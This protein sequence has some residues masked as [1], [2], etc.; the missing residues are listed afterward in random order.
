MEVRDI[1]NILLHILFLF[2]ILSVLFWKII[3]TEM[4]DHTEDAL[5]GPINTQL[6]NLT[7]KLQYNDSA[8]YK[9]PCNIIKNHKESV[10]K[11][12]NGRLSQLINEEPVKKSH[13]NHLKKV[14]LG[15]GLGL[16]VATILCGIWLSYSN[17]K[18][19]KKAHASGVQVDPE[20]EFHT[21]WRI[22]LINVG[23]FIGVGICEVIFFLFIAS[24][25]VP[26]GSSDASDSVIEQLIESFNNQ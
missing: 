26:I 22:I 24:K 13:N 17:H 23:L 10:A 15:I 3:A 19:T 5:R 6:N 21:W 11:N 2:S 20:V 14:N 4:D 16:L 25:Y 1:Y 9:V 7:H 12:I 18:K 8:L